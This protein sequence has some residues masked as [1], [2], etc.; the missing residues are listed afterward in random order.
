MSIRFSV[1]KW[2]VQLLGTKRLTSLPPEKMLRRIRHAN[3]RNHFFVPQ[4]EEFLYRDEVI[5]LTGI[6]GAEG[7]AD[8]EQKAS[9]HCLTICHKE[10][11][12]NA[13]KKRG[14]LCVYGGGMLLSPPRLFVG[15][16][17]DMAKKTGLD[18]WFPYY[19]LCDSYTIRDSVRMVYKVYESM[20]REYE[21]VCWYG[22]SSG[23]ALLLLL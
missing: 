2:L 18:V 21:E 11:A 19:P 22:Y 12:E 5:S 15:F 23:G 8:Q 13:P 16:A 14:I 6:D 1:M 20:C 10:Q 4:D 17:K 3:Q 9:F 7:F